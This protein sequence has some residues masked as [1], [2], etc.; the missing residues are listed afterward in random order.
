M[1][2]AQAEGN[3]SRLAGQE[4]P[5]QVARLPSDVPGGCHQPCE[6][7]EATENAV[8]D[9][10]HVV[11]R[12]RLPVQLAIKIMVA[13]DADPSLAAAASLPA[14]QRQAEEPAEQHPPDVGG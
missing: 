4:E 2:R 11:V 14:V 13:K 5:R 8:K 1:K 9:I 12:R 6:G 7:V 3:V 10:T